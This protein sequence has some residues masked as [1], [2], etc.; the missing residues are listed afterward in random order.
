MNLTIDL[1][2]V[3]SSRFFSYHFSYEGPLAENRGQARKNI[4]DILRH[5]CETIEAY[6][7]EF[8]PSK[9]GK[10]PSE[11]FYYL[12]ETDLDQFSHAA[13]SFFEEHGW[14]LQGTSRDKTE[15]YTVWNVEAWID[16]NSDFLEWFGSTGKS[17]HVHESR[18]PDE[19]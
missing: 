1:G 6:R 16:G 17:Y 2:W 8:C 11:F 5:L 12:L 10:D 15:A 13:D 14:H 4:P 9:V 3:E 7:A 18:L 19:D